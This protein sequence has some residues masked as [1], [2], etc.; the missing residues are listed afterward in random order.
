MWTVVGIIPLLLPIR[1]NNVTIA[2][3]YYGNVYV[4]ND[5]CAYTWSIIFFFNLENK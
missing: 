3:I 1:G 5:Q 4:L 2:L